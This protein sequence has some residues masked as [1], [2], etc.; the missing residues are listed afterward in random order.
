MKYRKTTVKKPVVKKV[1]KVRAKKNLF[2]KDKNTVPKTAEQI[3][4]N[5]D[6]RV[7]NINKK[8]ANLDNGSGSERKSGGFSGNKSTSDNQ[9][10][11]RPEKY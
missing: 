3:Q 7:A 2:Q 8:F 6:R 5:V 10:Y 1:F 4:A 11:K 9:S